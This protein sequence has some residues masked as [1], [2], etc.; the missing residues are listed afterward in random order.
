MIVPNNFTHGRINGLKHEND[1]FISDV[2][3]F[4]IL[5]CEFLDIRFYGDQ[6]LIA[7]IHKYSDSEKSPGL[8]RNCNGYVWID[9]SYFIEQLPCLNFKEAALKTRLKKLVDVGI[10]LREHEYINRGQVSKKAYYKVSPV[11]D[12]I[13]SITVKYNEI[14]KGNISPE[15][16]EI[17][18]K[19][20]KLPS[21]PCKVN[22]SLTKNNE[23][24][25]EKGRFLKTENPCKVNNSPECKVNE[26]LTPREIKTLHRGNNL[27]LDSYTK[28]HETKNKDI[29]NKETI[30]SDSIE[31]QVL[32]DIKNKSLKDI[33]KYITD[34]EIIKKRE[35]NKE[36]FVD[37]L[38]FD[39]MAFK[40]NKI[41]AIELIGCMR[42]TGEKRA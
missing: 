15:E 5:Y 17:K 2:N 33:P 6:V 38:G 8:Q 3:F 35:K 32:N 4:L 28:D 29:I 19:K 31:S 42:M 18:K 9:H 26:D 36:K 40:Y 22:K 14:E 23:K 27:P 25:D 20:I 21:V 1:I 41:G 39:C 7:T 34:E 37:C 16:K 10:L 13:D 30:Y 12:K 11:Y 24:R